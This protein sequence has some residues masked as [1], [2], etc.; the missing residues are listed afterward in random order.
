MKRPE[1]RG[2]QYSEKKHNQSSTSDQTLFHFAGEEYYIHAEIVRP[3]RCST[4]RAAKLNDASCTHGVASAASSHAAHQPVARMVLL[5]RAVTH[6]ANEMVARLL[7]QR[8]AAAEKGREGVAF[9]A[10]HRVVDV[11]GAQVAI[12]IQPL[13]GKVDG[14]RRW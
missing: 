3:R 14:G 10:L 4:A 9:R 7:R 2:G 13:G 5:H 1:N 12:L 6:S 11:L 8:V